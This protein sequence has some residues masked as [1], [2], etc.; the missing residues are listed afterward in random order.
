[1]SKALA[2]RIKSMKKRAHRQAAED[3]IAKASSAKDVDKA[4]EYLQ[5]AQEESR[6]AKAIRVTP[7]KRD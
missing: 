5:R 1:M 4:V 7:R 2:Q 3:F 6:K